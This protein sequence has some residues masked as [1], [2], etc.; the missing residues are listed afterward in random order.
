M[1]G[2][3]WRAGLAGVAYDVFTCPAAKSKSAWRTWKRLAEEMVQRGARPLQHGD[4]LRRRHRQRHGR[5]PGRHLH[6]RHPCPADPHHAAGAG[7]RRHRRQDRRQ[8]GERQ[9]PDRQLPSAARRAHRSRR[10]RYPARARIPRRALRNHQGR[11]HPRASALHISSPSISDDVLARDPDAVDHIIAESRAHEGRSGVQRRTRRRPAAHPE[12]RP[13]LRPRARSRDRYKRFLHGE[14]VAWGMRAA[15]YLAEIDGP[16]LG[17]RQ[18]RHP[19]NDRRSTG[20]SRRSTA[21]PRRTLFARLVHDKKTVQGKVHFVLP[22]RI[23][24][25]K[26]VSGIEEKPVLDAIRS[27]LA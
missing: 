26:V 12:F 19:G 24:E 3:H 22:V 14:A 2:A 13:H 1:Q 4:R 7:G 8:P 5:I 18:R 9:E 21:S 17:G 6:A 16:P 23:G 15:V 20:P 10:A 25:V 27:A 11:H